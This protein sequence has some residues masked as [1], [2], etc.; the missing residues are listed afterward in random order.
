MSKS[1]V[2][3]PF[4]NDEV[5]SA[6]SELISREEAMA[7]LTNNLSTKESRIEAMNNH[8]VKISK[9]LDEM[10]N[11]VRWFIY[12]EVTHIAENK[13]RG[14]RFASHRVVHLRCDQ[15]TP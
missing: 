6:L 7:D 3:P 14:F 8:S 5:R 4:A 1:F 11:E 10:Q 12:V 2:L 15:W 9:E 13:D